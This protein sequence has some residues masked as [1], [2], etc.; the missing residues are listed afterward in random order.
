MLVEG[1]MQAARERLVIIVDDARLIEAAK[2]LIA[3]TDLVAVCNGD[4]VLQGV[5]TKTDV[6]K[7]VSICGG[8]VCMLSVATVM[9]RDAALCGVAD[10]LADGFGYR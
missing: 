4:G 8:A 2:L 6:V 10:R 5:F 3:G 7:Q 9:A 1:L